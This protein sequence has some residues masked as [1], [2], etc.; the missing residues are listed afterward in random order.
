MVMV[1][2]AASVSAM[3]RG[4]RSPCGLMRSMTKCPGWAFRAI[5]GASS[6]S[7]LVL[8]GI[9]L[10]LC[11]M[12]VGIDSPVLLV[13]LPCNAPLVRAA[14]AVLVLRA[15]FA[16][17]RSPH[18]KPFFPGRERH[19]PSGGQV[20]KRC[21]ATFRRRECVSRETVWIRQKTALCC[22]MGCEPR[23][24]SK[25]SAWEHYGLRGP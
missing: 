21:A 13:D 16:G 10:S 22:R 24:G 7:L 17:V 23:G 20:P 5:C 11:R 4:M 12:G 8:P 19:C 15:P 2:L 9:R 6:T 1:P 14:N 25:Q 3:V 18:K